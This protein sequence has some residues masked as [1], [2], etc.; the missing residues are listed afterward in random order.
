[1]QPGPSHWMQ[2]R[3]ISSF[4]IVEVIMLNAYSDLQT[5]YVINIYHVLQCV[6]RGLLLPSSLPKSSVYRDRIE[7][8]LAKVF[9]K[10]VLRQYLP[11]KNRVRRT[12][13]SYSIEH[14]WKIC[15]DDHSSEHSAWYIILH[16]I[17]RSLMTGCH[18]R[19]NN[20]VK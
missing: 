6:L 10:S 13:F 19:I 11:G 17:L 7:H 3:E 4:S 16:G 20:N 5:P 2:L 18:E 1:M 12:L 8:F 14:F 9:G 15:S